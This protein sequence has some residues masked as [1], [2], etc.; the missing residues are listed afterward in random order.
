[1]KNLRASLSPSLKKAVWNAKYGFLQYPHLSAAEDAVSH[2]HANL[3]SRHTIL[4]L[5]CGRG[6]LVEGLR[7]AGWEGCYC[8][9]D[10]SERAIRDARKRED[11][12]SC[13]IA[14]DAESFRS[15]FQWDAIAM[16]ESVYYIDLDQI[17]S[18]LGRLNDMLATDGFLLIRLHDPEKYRNYVQEIKRCFPQLRIVSGQLLHVSKSPS[19]N[20]RS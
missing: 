4:E 14:S 7:Q 13:W 10:I 3:S 5:G 20:G 17:P 15:P 18:V 1:M 11:Q 2:L 6:S 12:R 9:V 8:G 16:I 19:E